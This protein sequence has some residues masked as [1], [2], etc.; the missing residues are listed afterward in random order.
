MDLVVDANILFS[1]LIKNG[2]TEEI[3]LEPDL[4]LFCPEFIFEELKNTKTTFS[5]RQKEQ[6]KNMMMFLM[7]LKL[8]SKQ[9]QT[10]KQKN[11]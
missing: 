6:K 3:M 1:I 7:L 8:K 2:K 10:K 9:F 5:R 11:I 4:H